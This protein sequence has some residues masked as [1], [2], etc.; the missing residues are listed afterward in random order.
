MKTYN[1]CILGFGNIG[2]ALAELLQEKADELSAAYG[3]E[4][5][6]TGV[7]TRRLGWLADANGLDV[8]ALLQGQFS[9]GPEYAKSRNVHEW[10]EAA[11]ANV[12]FELTSLNVQ[13]GQPAIE[14]IRAA[15]E[16]GAHVV[17]AN[18][19]PVVHA[20]A[21]LKALA[22]AHHTRFLF[23]AAVMGGAPL[24]TLFQQTLPAARLLRF[25]GLFNSTSNIV[26][27]EME[28]GRSFDEAVKKAQ[29][30]GL[31]ETDPSADV[32]GWDATVKVCALSTVLM[33]VPLQ[34]QDV[35]RTG[36]RDL[37]PEQLK[38]ARDEG[39]PFKLVARAERTGAG[40]IAT[41]RPE[42]VASDDPLSVKEA[43]S[44]LAHFEL[45]MVPGFTLILHVPDSNT[46][47]PRIVAYNVLTDFINAVK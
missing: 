34:P 30:M 2:R 44:L 8:S 47:G 43:G 35:A 10:L 13:T 40:V 37:Q 3:I 32:D 28:Q 14:H 24:F 5:R 31:A 41:V 18:K 25:S 22:D 26:L 21:Q 17:T 29:E 7:A 46:T 4:W 45:D 20:H 23:D 9:G 12:L 42:Q 33:G 19:G 38:A 11:Q 36:I 27:A 1:L 16:R 39:R 15:L 6:V